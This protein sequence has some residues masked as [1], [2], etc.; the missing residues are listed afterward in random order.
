VRLAAERRGRRLSERISD[1]G[2]LGALAEKRTNGVG[3]KGR[4]FLMDTKLA[5]GQF[6]AL[7]TR[8]I[9]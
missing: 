2:T 4:K 8:Q 7:Y 3:N 5:D 1:A 9:S 6:T